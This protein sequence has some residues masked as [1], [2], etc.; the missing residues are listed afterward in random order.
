MTIKP[1]YE[2]LVQKVKE[3]EEET[4]RRKQAAEALMKSEERYRN[5]VEDQTEFIVRWLP[6]GIRTFVNESYC[7]FFGQTQEE[8]I[9][10]SFFPQITEEDRE[11]VQKRIE[12]LTPVCSIDGQAP[13]CLS[14]W[15]HWLESMDG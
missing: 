7:R 10:S 13:C 11:M 15:N 5:I 12:A 6:G 1:S 8:A 14:R 4:I 2:E 9:G 3:L